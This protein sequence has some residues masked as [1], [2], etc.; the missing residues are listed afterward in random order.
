MAEIERQGQMYPNPPTMVDVAERAGVSRGTVSLALRHDPKL[1]ESTTQHVLSVA[2][3]MGYDPM[4]YADARRLISRRHGSDVPSQTL[5]LSFQHKDFSES[6]Y[7]TRVFQ[8]VLAGA[9]TRD[10][11]IH[12]TDNQRIVDSGLPPPYRRGDLDGLLVMNPQQYW[13]PI[14]QL[15]RSEPGFGARPIVGLVEP[16]EDTSS[17]APDSYAAGYAIFSHLLDLG[18]RRILHWESGAIDG[19]SVHRSRMRAGHDA[20]LKRSLDPSECL[21]WGHWNSED[22]EDT[23]IRTLS[24]LRDHPDVTAILTRNDVEAGFLYD[25]LMGEGYRI[26]ADYSLGSF[27]DTEPILNAKRGNILTT[28]RLPLREVGYEGA[29]LLVRR[30]LL[31]EKRDRDLVLPVELVVR[32]STSSPRKP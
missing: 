28:V 14:L 24:T 19:T 16:L 30:V 10:F 22:L 1:P 18:H 17:V 2:E 12:T 7:F 15:L 4:H 20:C 21:L 27:D 9:A 13:L 25:V 11:E 29:R 8:G 5:G 31:E 23:R 32:G 6:N 3:A 26:P